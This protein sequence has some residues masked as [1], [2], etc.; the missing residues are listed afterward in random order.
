ITSSGWPFVFAIPVYVPHLVASITP[1]SARSCVMQA[2]VEIVLVIVAATIRVVVV[3]ESSSVV[4]LSFVITRYLHLRASF[5]SGY[6]VVSSA[7]A[8]LAA[9]ASRAATTLSSISRLMAACFMAS[10]SDA[11]A[12]DA[13]FL[14]G[15]ILST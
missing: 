7:F 12:A 6:Q 9:C 11:D 10:A 8:M 14:L 3:V 1:D 4:K 13:E 2:V 15:G 5:G